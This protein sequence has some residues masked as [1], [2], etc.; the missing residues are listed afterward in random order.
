MSL[1]VCQPTNTGAIPGDHTAVT[2]H[3]QIHGSHMY[4]QYGLQ[5]EK[6]VTPKFQDRWV[7][8]RVQIVARNSTSGLA[9]ASLGHD[10]G[11]PSYR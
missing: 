3:I 9:G 6:C 11:I 7:L 1:F 8:F 2:L 10:M 4:T 5:Y